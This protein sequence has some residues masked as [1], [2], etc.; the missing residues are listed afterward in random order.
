VVRFRTDDVVD[1]SLMPAAPVPQPRT[2]RG[3]AAAVLLMAAIVAAAA[4]C[5]SSVGNEPT[6]GTVNFEPKLTVAVGDGTLAITTGPRVDPAVTADPA[7]V[8]SGTVIEVRNVGRAQHRLVSG[9]AV[10]TGIQRPGD[11][12]T[13]VL[14]NTTD[15]DVHL[16]LTDT[17]DPNVHGTIT[18]KPAPASS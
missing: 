9:T 1:P 8:P 13:V 11:T 6:L 3:R 4:A 10:D 5:V 15:S 18:V 2:V 7:V 17:L 12:T 16:D 14:T